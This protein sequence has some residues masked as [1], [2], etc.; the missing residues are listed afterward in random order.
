MGAAAFDRRG[1]THW[2]F[3]GE[4]AQAHPAPR[5]RLGPADINPLAAPTRGCVA[6]CLN[7]GIF[8]KLEG[9]REIVN[10]GHV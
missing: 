10:A 1:V 4:R 9:D 6:L 8:L 3:S 5:E 2:G 7:N